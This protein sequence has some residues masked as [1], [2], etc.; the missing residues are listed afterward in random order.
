[1]DMLVNVVLYSVDGTVRV[2]GTVVVL[3]MDVVVD[4][5]DDNV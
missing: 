2:A 5:V 3:V 4:A 1:M